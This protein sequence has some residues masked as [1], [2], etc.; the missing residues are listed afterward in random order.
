MMRKNAVILLVIVVGAVLVVWLFNFLTTGTVTL[1]SNDPSVGLTLAKV[2]QANSIKTGNRSLTARL[3]A[4]AYIA[5]AEGGSKGMS[6]II[7]VRAHTSSKYSLN[8]SEPTGV[9]PVLYVN[10]SYLAASTSQLYFMNSDNQSLYKIN[11]QNDVQQVDSSHFLKLKWASSSKGIAQDST[12]RLFAIQNGSVH[13][14]AIPTTTADNFDIAPNGDVFFSSNKQIYRGSLSGSFSKIYSSSSPFTSLA[15]SSKGVAVI[16]SQLAESSKNYKTFVTFIGDAGNIIQKNI[17]AYDNSSWSPSGQYLVSAGNLEYGIFNSSLERV[18]DIPNQAISN[19]VW[20]DNY[21]L[22]YSV[23]D[24][25]WQYD[26]GTSAAKLIANMPLGGDIS[27]I[28]ISDGGEYVYLSVA[29][30]NGASGSIKR[31]GLKGQSVPSIVY[32]L[33]DILPKNLEDCTIS[34]VNFTAPAVLVSSSSPDLSQLCIKAASD[35]LSQ[36]GFNLNQLQ[37][38][39]AS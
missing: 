26:I 5:M 31:V 8:P 15:A 38:I 7:K 39:P 25:L 11:N 27:Q 21:R 4:G 17:I 28:A 34:L 20:L 16:S 23:K 9:E 14:L 6:Q 19:P 37:L 10:G 1:T 36:D 3:K 12:G 22:I 2:G 32:Q 24:Q 13:Q 30:I 29:G 33:Q 18:A 35:E